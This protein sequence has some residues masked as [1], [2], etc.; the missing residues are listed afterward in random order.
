MSPRKHH[1]D[2]GAYGLDLMRL[3]TRDAVAALRR[4]FESADMLL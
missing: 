3:E 2:S 1:L 4:G